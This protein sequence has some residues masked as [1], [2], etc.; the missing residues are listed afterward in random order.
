MVYSSSN[1]LSIEEIDKF[2]R[3]ARFFWN[4]KNLNVE[5]ET[6][7][8]FFEFLDDFKKYNQ[9]YLKLSNYHK[10]Q[11]EKKVEQLR[12]FI[13]FGVNLDSHFEEMALKILHICKY[14]PNI[15]LLFF[16]KG[17]NPFVDEEAENFKSNIEFFQQEILAYISDFYDEDDFN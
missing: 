1:K 11:I 3:N 9:S 5:N 10:N 4:Y 12:K 2:I 15:A 6:S 7:G 17:I 8:N 14:K 16:F 13:S